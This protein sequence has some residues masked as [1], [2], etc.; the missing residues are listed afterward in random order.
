MKQVGVEFCAERLWKGLEVSRLRRRRF[1]LAYFF[2]FGTLY[3][4]NNGPT[5]EP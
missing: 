2:I 5:A 4:C 1:I 3:L